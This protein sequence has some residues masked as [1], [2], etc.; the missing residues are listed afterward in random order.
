MVKELF[1]G[2]QDKDHRYEN[3]LL[4]RLSGRKL[5]LRGTHDPAKYIYVNGEWDIF[6]Q[7]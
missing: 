5:I 3:C 6:L 1:N 7:K 4:V 2:G